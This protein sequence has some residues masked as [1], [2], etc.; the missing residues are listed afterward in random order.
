PVLSVLLDAPVRPADSHD[1][2][3]FALKKDRQHRCIECGSVY[4]M[5]FYGEEHHDHHHH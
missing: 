3:W 5:D 1:V 4:K 2:L